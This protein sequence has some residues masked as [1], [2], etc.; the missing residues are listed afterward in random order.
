MAKV[1]VDSMTKSKCGM[2]TALVFAI[3]CAE[4][5]GEPHFGH[6]LASAHAS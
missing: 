3:V 6:A 5:L 1:T 2:V 4:F